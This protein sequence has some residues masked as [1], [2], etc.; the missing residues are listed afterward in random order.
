MKRPTIFLSSTIYD[1]RDLRSAL[2]YH[3]ELQ[4]C[5]V[6]ASEFNDFQKPL[7]EHSYDACL[8]SIEQCDYFI[9]LIGSRVGGMYDPDSQI[10]I[11]QKEYRTAYEL[12][13]LGRLHIMTFVRGEVWQVKEDR[14]A[15]SKHLRELKMK[16]SEVTRVLAYP[17]KFASDAEFISSFIEEVG[18][19]I[20]TK[21]AIAEGLPR[22]TGNWIHVF[23]DYA[24]IVAAVDP[25][26]LM[27]LPA[28]EAYFR[29]ALE[30]EII[31]ILGKC[32][33]KC[34]NGTVRS[35]IPHL[36]RIIQK[37]PIRYEEAFES[38]VV[39]PT[40]EWDRFAVP[41]LC[42]P[43]GRID[44]VILRNALSASTFFQFDVSEGKFQDT[45]ARQAINQLYME[46][47]SFNKAKDSDTHSVLFEYAPARRSPS[48]EEVKIQTQK[49]LPIY[50]LIHRWGNIFLLGSAI[51]GYLRSGNFDEP[52]LFPISPIEGMDKDLLRETVTEDE[53]LEFLNLRD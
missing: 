28:H 48:P 44:A 10:S 46:I 33:I 8:K 26:I 25:V 53:V 34:R 42:I 32:L 30:G 38:Y 43:R 41:L 29:R 35:P 31:Q 50:H 51:I 20:E 5:S 16:E 24:E 1:F 27:G 17:N 49:L 13:K 45:P 15:L 52:Q 39:I 9:L 11:T 7:D 12:H 6:L 40:S 4:G 21:S 19:N 18:R 22:P 37:Y 3:L 47:N 23:K 14:R 2:K 36:R